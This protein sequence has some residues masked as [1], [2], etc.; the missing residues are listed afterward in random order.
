MQ[1]DLFEL[2]GQQFGEFFPP[3]TKKWK[4]LLEFKET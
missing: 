1:E 2:V 4:I 3:M